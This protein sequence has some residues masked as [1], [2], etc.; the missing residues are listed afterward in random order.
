MNSHNPGRWLRHVLHLRPT[1]VIRL[2]SYGARSTAATGSGAADACGHLPGGHHRR[3]RRGDGPRRA[4][5]I[6]PV[7]C[8]RSASATRPSSCRWS[9]RSAPTRGT[10]CSPARAPPSCTRSSSW[11]GA[12][13][14]A[15]STPGDLLFHIRAEIAGRLLRTG[16]P[17]RQRDGRRDH[18]RR[19]G[20]RLQVLRQPR[21]AGLRRRHREPR[22]PSRGER[23]PDRRRGSRLRGR[24]LRAR[25]EVPARHGVV[26]F[27]VGRPSRSG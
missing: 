11:T 22:R 26:E 15:P 20:A 13:H 24:L 16:R 1:S 27:A 8:A 14:D 9:P 18:R 17:D 12:R 19:R 2:G 5:P 21:P 25:A 4:R 10:G 7:W 6:C 23:H 3:R